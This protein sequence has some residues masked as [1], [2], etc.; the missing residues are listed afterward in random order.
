MNRLFCLIDLDG[1]Q[2]RQANDSAC[3]VMGAKER[4]LAIAKCEK[5]CSK[6]W[7][8]NCKVCDKVKFCRV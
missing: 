6:I 8:D 4:D 7:G 1:R 2:S 5:K 3:I